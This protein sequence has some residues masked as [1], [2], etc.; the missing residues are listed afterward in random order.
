MNNKTK[1]F[2]K[3]QKKIPIVFY[4]LQ[5]L[6]KN[7]LLTRKRQKASKI[8]FTRMKLCFEKTN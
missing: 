2:H 8:S 1:R 6:K 4:F 5:Y 3:I 7:I